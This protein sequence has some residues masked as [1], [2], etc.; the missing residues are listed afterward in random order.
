M[1]TQD[2]KT[3]TMGGYFQL[4]LSRG[5]EYYPDL[6]RLNTSRNALGYILEVK[7]YTKIYIPYF[8]CEVMLEPLVN[9]NIPYQF[10]SID[11]QL[12]PIFDFEIGP[13]ECMLYNNYFGLKDNAVK[14]FSSTIDHIIID[15]AQAFFSEPLPKTDTFYSCRKFFGVPD[16]AYLQLNTDARLS[17]EKDISVDRFSHLINSIDL[18]VE[19][20]YADFI[21]NED[22]LINN[23]IRSMSTLTQAILSNI[24]YEASKNRRIRNFN[25]LNEN[26]AQFN[27][28]EIDFPNGT[29]AML[30]PLLV[31][32]PDVKA[33]L[34]AKKIFV[35]TYWPNIFKWTKDDTLEYKL[36]K[37]VIYLPIDQRYGLKDMEY[38]LDIL[39][40]I[41]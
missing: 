31:S 30:F 40:K 39:K 12:E 11:N 5:M 6:I 22:G 36:A 16:G 10:Y 21:E 13:T 17:L 26:L 1:Q 15:N 37:D 20:G 3:K 2:S 18:G 28:L 19:H 34:I 33:K 24:D 23:E 9:L 7:K 38:M 8:T 32:K 4:H 27:E 41:I 29:P 35:P 25:F 14:Q